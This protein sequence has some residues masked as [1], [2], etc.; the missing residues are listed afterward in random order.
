MASLSLLRRCL[1][2]PVRPDVLNA[3]V[4]AHLGWSSVAVSMFPISRVSASISAIDLGGAAAGSLPA[5]SR[6]AT[7]REDLVAEFSGRPSH[8]DG[9]P[10]TQSGRGDM[11][12]IF[13]RTSSHSA[14]A[15][16]S[17][18][19]PAGA[20]KLPG[21]PEIEDYFSDIFERFLEGF[22]VRSETS[23][24]ERRTAIMTTP[25]LTCSLRSLDVTT[26]SGHRLPQL[27]QKPRIRQRVPQISMS[28]PTFRDS[29]IFRVSASPS[30]TLT[31]RVGLM[32]GQSSAADPDGCGLTLQGGVVCGIISGSMAQRWGEFAKGDRIISISGR[33]FGD[34]AALSDFLE[35]GK[36]AYLCTVERRVKVSSSPSSLRTPL[37]QRALK[38]IGLTSSGN[39]KPPSPRFTTEE[40]C[41]AALAS[42]GDYLKGGK[43][44]GW[45]GRG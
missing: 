4:L 40:E 37:R 3:D 10:H 23:E 16:D 26:T 13:W 20:A 44:F 9:T 31:T 21:K 27:R 29:G 36:D 34:G 8:A 14:P 43:R 33:S 28:D 38:T 22:T 11:S 2:F 45:S 25:D 17:A 32:R 39:A 35:P 12:A 30:A 19:A 6:S 15:G 1:A 7:P 24:E 5:A 42:A 18:D 41:A